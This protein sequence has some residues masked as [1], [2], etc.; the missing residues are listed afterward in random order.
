[1][2]DVSEFRPLSANVAGTQIRVTF[3]GGIRVLFLVSAWRRCSAEYVYADSDS[4]SMERVRVYALP[5]PIITVTPGPPKARGMHAGL[6]RSSLPSSPSPAVRQHRRVPGG[7]GVAGAGGAT[8][9][10][11][12]CR[13]A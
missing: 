2:P 13:L 8:D 3:T 4:Y 9:R 1:M 7:H 6:Q 12:F 11:G 10:C 5:E